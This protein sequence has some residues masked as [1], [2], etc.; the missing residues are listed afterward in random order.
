L[1]I[2]C[3][4]EVRTLLKSLGFADA[5]DAFVDGAWK[6]FDADGNGVLDE[7]E[8]HD[9]VCAF[10]QRITPAATAAAAL[11]I[12]CFAKRVS[13]STDGRIFVNRWKC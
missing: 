4:I 10:T 3:Q 5:S 7:E 2:H 13:E 1:P 6:V 12:V 8:V 9:M 11:A